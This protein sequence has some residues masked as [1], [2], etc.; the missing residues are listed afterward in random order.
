MHTTTWGSHKSHRPAKSIGLAEILAAGESI[1]SG[2]RLVKCYQELLNIKVGL[3]I[4][5][6][7]KDLYTT[8]STCRNSIEKSIKNEFETQMF[9]A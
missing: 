3:D 6:D 7:T 1:G 2:K 8:L 9:L 4:V 5:V